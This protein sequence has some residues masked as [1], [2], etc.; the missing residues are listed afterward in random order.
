M[1]LLLFLN[2]HAI[3]GDGDEEK[4]YT[5]DSYKKY[6]EVINLTKET[7]IRLTENDVPLI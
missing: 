1:R 6:P 3:L 4:E 7:S 5:V 2:L